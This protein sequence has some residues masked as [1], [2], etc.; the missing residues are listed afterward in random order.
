MT[1]SKKKVLKNVLKE[2]TNLF[3]IQ[4][5]MSLVSAMFLCVSVCLSIY[6][7]VPYASPFTPM[8]PQGSQLELVGD[9]RHDSP[10]FSLALH[11]TIPNC[12]T[13]HTGHTGHTFHT[14]HTSNNA[15]FRR[16]TQVTRVRQ[17]TLFTRV[18]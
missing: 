8:F 13:S 14:C 4:Y 18:T 7:C 2:L 9:A 10:G 3:F 16:V 12:H 15:L 11:H 1:K 6:I 5:S 17:V